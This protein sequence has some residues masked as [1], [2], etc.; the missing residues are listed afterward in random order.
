MMPSHKIIAAG[1]AILLGGV[2]LLYRPKRDDDDLGKVKVKVKGKGGSKT[3]SGGGGS[4]TPSGGGVDLYTDAQVES[5]LRNNNVSIRKADHGFF[6]VGTDIDLFVGD[7]NYGDAEAT[8][9]GYVNPPDSHREVVEFL[10]TAVPE[11]QH[12]NVMPR[13][14]I[15]IHEMSISSEDALSDSKVGTPFTVDEFIKKEGL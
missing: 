13:L 7:K 8:L 4:K 9:Q 3:P 1:A 11:N 2:A 10:L 6:A 5:L 15:L 12:Q 14:Y